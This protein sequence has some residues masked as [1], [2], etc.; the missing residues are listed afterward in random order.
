MATIAVVDAQL[1]GKS[2][3]EEMVKRSPWWKRIKTKEPTN[4]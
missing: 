4:Q 1:K 2:A 3:T